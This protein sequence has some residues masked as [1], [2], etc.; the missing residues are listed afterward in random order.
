[1][2]H[3]TAQCGESRQAVP[4]AKGTTESMEFNLGSG[5]IPEYHLIQLIMAWGAS[6]I[7][8]EPAKP[9]K[10]GTYSALPPGV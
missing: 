10:M 2:G 3:E 4:V 8:P 5:R 1:M 9:P 6:P 7:T